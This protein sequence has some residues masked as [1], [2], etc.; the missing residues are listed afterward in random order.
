MSLEAARLLEASV[1]AELVLMVT[2]TTRP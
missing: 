2:D 1:A